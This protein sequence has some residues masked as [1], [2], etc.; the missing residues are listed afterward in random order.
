[1][2]RAI[3]FRA[4][5]FTLFWWVVAEGRMNSWG[6]GVVA[7]TAALWTSLRLLPPATLPI[8]LPGLLTFLGYFL[9]NSA[10]GGMQVSWLALRGRRA[11]RPALLQFELGLP[12]GAPRFVL[13]YALG[14]MPGTLGVELAGETLRFHVVDE[15]A[16]TLGKLEELQAHIARM[17]GVQP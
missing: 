15:R 2:N 5:L 8:S 16:V 12:P 13:L 9:W 17:F 1:M 14:L 4:L 7:V 6:L 11:L 10:S 3:P